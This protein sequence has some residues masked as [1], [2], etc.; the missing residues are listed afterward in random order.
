MNLHFNHP[1]EITPEVKAACERL[2]D[3]GVPLGSQTV[4]LKGVNDDP[5][6]MKRLMQK[7]LTCRVKPYYLYQADLTQGTNHFRT[8]VEEGLKIIKAI[9]GHTSGMAVPHYVIDTPGGGG[10]IPLLPADYLVELN[11]QEAVLKNYENRTFRYPQAEP[12][13]VST[14]THQTH[15]PFKILNNGGDE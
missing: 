10:K 12:E 15:G 3:A 1:D 5:D 7:L 4:L 11:P 13:K 14:T 9:Q 2:A 6:V 8:T